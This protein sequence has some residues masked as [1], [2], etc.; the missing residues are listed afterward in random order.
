MRRKH[1]FIFAIIPQ[2][3]QTTAVYAYLLWKYIAARPSG[4]M[5]STAYDLA[6]WDTT[7]Y[8][9]FR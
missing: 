6:K 9:D 5:L 4:A 2:S 3:P 8:T 7:F 1:F